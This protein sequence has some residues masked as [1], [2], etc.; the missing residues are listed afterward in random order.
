MIAW[1]VY[2]YVQ[3]R[4]KTP[5]ALFCTCVYKITSDRRKKE[6]IPKRKKNEQNGIEIGKKNP[7]NKW[8]KW[9]YQTNEQT[10]QTIMSKFFYE[11]E[12]WM[13]LQIEVHPTLKRTCIGFL[14]KTTWTSTRKVYILDD[15]FYYPP[16]VMSRSQGDSLSYQRSKTVKSEINVNPKHFLAD[17][18]YTLFLMRKE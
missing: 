2:V 18:V 9:T 1:C 12:L 15:P 3:T 7:Q 4:F 5:A 17:F 14:R 8:I 6:D 16:P 11:L 10:N 13:L